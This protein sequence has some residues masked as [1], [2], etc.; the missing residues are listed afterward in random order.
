MA[1]KTQLL[2]D[3]QRSRQQF[4]GALRSLARAVP[5]APDHL[6]QLLTAWAKVKRDA[7]NRQQT[8]C[9]VSSD[10]GG[11]GGGGTEW[12]EVMA[13][14]GRDIIGDYWRKTAKYGENMKT[15]KKMTRENNVCWCDYSQAK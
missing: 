11:G 12:S 13:L 8:D 10:G 6:P 4:G 5:L 7:L 1:S 15:T 2:V 3:A 14:C 9:L